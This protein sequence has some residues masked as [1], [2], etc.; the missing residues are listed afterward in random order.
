MGFVDTLQAIRKI[1]NDYPETAHT[2]IEDK[3]N[4]SAVIDALSR[5]FEGVVPVSPEGGKIARAAAVSY[6]IEN[7]KVHLPKYE[8]WVEDYLKETG[9]FPAGKHDDQVDATSQAL[10]RLADIEATDIPTTHRK[11]VH[12]T[13]DM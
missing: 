6:L 2:Y 9:A 13:A 4:G 3:A 11:Y 12:Y 8:S 5:E 1:L 10:N 7:G